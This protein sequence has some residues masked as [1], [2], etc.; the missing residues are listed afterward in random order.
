MI[1]SIFYKEWI[2]SRWVLLIV[3]VVF[4]CVLTYSFM[5]LSR[6][7]RLMGADEYWEM[8]VQ[9]EIT[10]M[11]Y[12][13][14]LPLLAGILLA[15]AQFTPEMT[16]KRL[17]L[18]LHLPLSESKII[19]TMLSFGIGSLAVLF[20]LTYVTSSIGLSNFFAREIVC[21]N[22]AEL[23]PWLLGGIASYLFSVW[24]CLEPV[25]KQRVLK[26]ILALCGISLYYQSE[27]LGAYA[28]FI[29]WLILL[30][31]LSPAFVFHS[32]IRFKDGEQ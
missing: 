16:N 4:A 24:I 21:W 25:W 7:F 22:L 26:A 17:K 14:Y 19:L 28:P 31:V 5:S 15:L 9:K 32:L 8:V 1:T 29:A 3:A 13:K 6:N 20:I 10:S 23:Y 27:M 2:K 11:G 18:T 12:I 30:M